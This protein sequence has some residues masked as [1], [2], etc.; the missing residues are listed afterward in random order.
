MKKLT[1]KIILFLLPVFLIMA[2]PA[3]VA[4]L[5]GELSGIRTV[6]QR[7]DK[8]QGLYGAAYSNSQALYKIEKTHQTQPSV[9]VLGT[10]RAMQLRS[11]FFETPFYNAGGGIY[12][13]SDLQLFMNE[14]YNEGSGLPSLLILPLDQYFFN[15]SWVQAQDTAFSIADVDA[16]TLHTLQ[17]TAREIVAGRVTSSIVKRML[18]GEEKNTGMTAIVHGDGFRTDGS[19]LYNRTI[20]SGTTPEQRF[21]ESYQRIEG[22]YNRFEY[23][24]VVYTPQLEVLA[25]FLD[26]C[27]ANHIHV[28][29]FLPPYADAVWDRMRETGMYGYLD[30]L[31]GELLPLFESRSYPLFDFSRMSSAGA[32]DSECID[33]FHGSEKTFLRTTIIMARHDSI[34][35][36]HTDTV[37]LNAMLQAT[38]GH[39]LV[40]PPDDTK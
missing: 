18:A 7:Q 1:V 21:T 38:E 2:I 19:Y 14:A 35:R 11:F 20:H 26:Y 12:K 36:I 31:Y 40:Q 37:R 27:R 9:L 25:S 30:K 32:P 13:L 3:G 28:I 6:I 23:A 29:A 15:R 34:M 39:F 17:Q 16:L 24:D 22:G 10:S 5:T 8:T 4:Y 33:G